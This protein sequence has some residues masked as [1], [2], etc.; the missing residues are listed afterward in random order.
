MF[1]AVVVLVVLSS[2]SFSLSLLFPIP[3]HFTAK[4]SVISHG[5]CWIMNFL[6]RRGPGASALKMIDF[7]LARHASLALDIS[8]LIYSCTSQQ[9]REEHY[10][11]SL[12]KAYHESVIRT[13]SDLGIQEPE[14]LLSWQDL[15]LEM[16]QFA[17]FGCGMGI[18]SLPMSLLEYDEVSDLDEIGE[19]TKLNDV[20]NIA[21]FKDAE[22]QQRIADIFKHAIDLNYIQ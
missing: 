15:L 9:L 19:H 17:R 8:F 5:D 11:K 13:L 12:L 18:E 4:L 6:I 22:K 21:P 1:L 20:W 7:Q 14:E 10:E 2:L 16:Q 3:L